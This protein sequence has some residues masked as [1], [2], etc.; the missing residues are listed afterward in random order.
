MVL[1]KPLLLVSLHVLYLRT[2]TYCNTARQAA[3][4][5]RHQVLPAP[6]RL[7]LKRPHLTSLQVQNLA[8]V[9]KEEN[10]HCSPIS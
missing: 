8:T 3:M 9:N 5:L 7:T 2:S 4:Y 10:N 1:P 6:R